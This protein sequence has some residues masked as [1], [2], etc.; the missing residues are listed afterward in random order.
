MG[1]CLGDTENSTVV[2][3][4][5]ADVVARGRTVGGGV[6]CT[7]DGTKALASEIT[8]V[9]GYAAVI[10]HCTLHK[11]ELDVAEIGAPTRDDRRVASYVAKYATKTTGGSVALAR[12]FAS[13]GEIEHAKIAT[14]YR[15][16]ALT[17]WDLEREPGLRSLGLR[18][19]A[20]ALGFRGQLVTKSRGYSTTFTRL[21]TARVEYHSKAT[22][23]GP[24]RA[25]SDTPVAATTIPCR[26]HGRRR[27]PR[28][29]RTTDARRHG[30]ERSAET[31]A[32]T[33]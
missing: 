1:L 31:R 19:H 7:I 28:V 24:V 9:F 27:W 20:H 2:K 17:A 33:S 26:R 18:R 25:R 6:L 13:R 32:K 14:H 22:G 11:R 8:R 29:R 12:R 10:Q 16:L 3:S 15:Q 5:L 30:V 21:L 23:D 4:L